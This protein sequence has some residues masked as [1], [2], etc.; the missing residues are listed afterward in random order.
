MPEQPETGRQS[1]ETQGPLPPHQGTAIG[2]PGASQGRFWS[3]TLPWP[4]HSLSPNGRTHWRVLAKA[5]ARY[6]QQCAD[7]VQTTVGLPPRI[8]TIPTDARVELVMVFYPPTSRGYDLDNLH[9]RMKSGL[10]GLCDVLRINDRQFRPVT[11]DMGKKH[12]GGMV[13]TILQW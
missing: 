3:I 6:R 11:V 8:P 2:D 7:H 4:H 9:A 13:V 12:L 1:R 5:K 10:D